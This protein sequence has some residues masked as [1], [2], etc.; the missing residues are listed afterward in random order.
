M[1][2]ESITKVLLWYFQN[3]SIF[4]KI[5]HGTVTTIIYVIYES[6]K[7]PQGAINHFM[8][9]IIDMV[10]SVF[11]STPDSFTVGHNLQLFAD[12]YPEIGW[13]VLFEIYQGFEVMFGLWCVVTLWKLLPFT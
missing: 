2:I 1:T 11:P 7:N 4:A 10:Y 12:S 9:L 8:I 6:I 5:S 3:T 13:G